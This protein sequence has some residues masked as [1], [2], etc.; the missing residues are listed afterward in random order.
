MNVHLPHILLDHS[1]DHNRRKKVRNQWSG[2]FRKPCNIV[3][4]RTKMSRK[5]QE[6][7]GDAFG[8]KMPGVRISPLGPKPSEID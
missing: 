5:T 2:A 7:W 4:K 8:I 6:N 1:F 3:N